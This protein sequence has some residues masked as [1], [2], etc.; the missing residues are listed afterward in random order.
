MKFIG[1]FT[2]IF[3]VLLLNNGNAQ[4][5]GDYYK[6]GFKKMNPVIIPEQYSNIV[7]HWH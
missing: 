6:D 5:Q 3:L 2:A 1:T 7:K 4:S